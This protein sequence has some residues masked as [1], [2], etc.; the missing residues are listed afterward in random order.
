MTTQHI[1]TAFDD[2][3]NELDQ[4]ISK[5][6]NLALSQFIAV[7][8]GLEQKDDDLKSLIANDRLIDELEDQVYN[9][10]VEI[11]AIRAPQA[12]DLRHIIIAPKIA[13]FLERIGDYSKNII[14][15]RNMM[16][17]EGSDLTIL[18]KLNAMSQMARDL[19]VD[20]LEALTRRD[21]T[22]A[23][24]VWE[25]DV[26]LDA[27]HSLVYKSIYRDMVENGSN[28]SGINALFIAKNIERIGDF[29]TS[30]AEQ[31]YFVVHGE[32]L[33]SERPK[34][35]ITTLKPSDG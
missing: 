14:K 10:T 4:L 15:R 9:K 19:L 22:K 16:I 27:L 20:V 28:P 1:S 29:C 30:I 24:L 2:D 12:N 26:E 33:D 18:G 17:T 5:M 31:V 6:G 23:R 35:D 13:S 7:I 21:A 11:I 34:G 8:D 3:L 25:G 32:M